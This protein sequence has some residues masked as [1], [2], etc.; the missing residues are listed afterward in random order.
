MYKTLALGVLAQAAFANELFLSDSIQSVSDAD[1]HEHGH[2]LAADAAKF[3]RDLFDSF[4]KTTTGKKITDKFDE[5]FRGAMY[6]AVLAKIGDFDFGAYMRDYEQ[7]ADYIERLTHSVKQQKS[8]MYATHG[9]GEQPTYTCSTREDPDA[10]VVYYDFLPVFVGDLTMDNSFLRYDGKCFGD[11]KMS[12]EKLSDSQYEVTFDLGRPKSLKPG[13]H[14]TFMLGNTEV[15]HLDAYFTR[16][17]HKITFDMPDQDSQD[18]AAFGGIK[19]YSFCGSVLDEIES[20]LKTLSL[21]VGGLSDN[22]RIPI[23]GS[24]IPPYMEKANLEFLEASMGMTL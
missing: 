1:V 9:L 11:T 6:D 12:L 21:F 8:S 23:F 20:V 22:P 10:P 2:G 19:V 5:E 13:C 17:A 3:A 7:Q 4:K 15:V 24:H 18:D 14:D 16:G